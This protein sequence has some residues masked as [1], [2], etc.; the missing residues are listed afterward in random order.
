[1]QRFFFKLTSLVA[2]ICLCCLAIFRVSAQPERVIEEIEIRG[3][4]AVPVEYVKQQIKTKVG[5]PHNPEQVRQDFEAVLKTGCFDPFLC[6]VTERRAPKGGL[7]LTFTLKENA[8]PCPAAT[9]KK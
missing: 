3:I 9:K 4:N 7:L 6:S 8:E 5:D 2:L 1:M